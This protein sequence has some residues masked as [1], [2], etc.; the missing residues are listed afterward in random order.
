MHLSTPK[1]RVTATTW[2]CVRVS[3]SV[4]CVCLSLQANNMT[5]GL[6]VGQEQLEMHEVCGKKSSQVVCIPIVVGQVDLLIIC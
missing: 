5:G 1:W 2:V 4:K 3:G 6:S